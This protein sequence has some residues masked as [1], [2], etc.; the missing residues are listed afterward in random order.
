MSVYTNASFSFNQTANGSGS[1]Y[2]NDF[3][4]GQPE[5]V[6]LNLYQLNIDPAGL[7]DVQYL[8]WNDNNAGADAPVG[9]RP[10]WTVDYLSGD[11]SGV[12]GVQHTMFAGYIADFVNGGPTGT[13]TALLVGYGQAYSHEFYPS[14]PGRITTPRVGWPTKAL[15]TLV[16][17]AGTRITIALC[18][19]GTWLPVL[20]SLTPSLATTVPEP[21]TIAMLIAA[22]LALVGY[23]L[24]RRK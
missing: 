8:A 20:G 14:G 12:S 19:L 6:G 1:Y 7:D 11:D 13:T 17:Q 4:D 18:Y 21:G 23:A 5:Q 10:Q 22:G 9:I 15:K 16:R 3:P 24:R 2:A